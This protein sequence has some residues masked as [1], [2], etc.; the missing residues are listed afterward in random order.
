MNPI[1]NEVS[2]CPTCG[3]YDKAL[4]Y[5]KQYGGEDYPCPN[6]WHTTPSD[7][8]TPQPTT[9]PEA[10]TAGE[11]GK[12]VGELMC[13]MR[14]MGW[15]VAVHNDYRLG[16]KDHTFWLFTKGEQCVK[17]EGV[18]DYSALMWA[19][20]RAQALA[21]PIATEQAKQVPSVNQ[22][23]EI[24]RKAIEES[25]SRCLITDCSRGAIA[26][27]REACGRGYSSLV[28]DLR[29]KLAWAGVEGS[30]PPGR[31]GRIQ[32]LEQTVADLRKEAKKHDQLAS[33]LTS[34]LQDCQIKLDDAIKER[35][36]AKKAISQYASHAEEMK[37]ELAEFV[38]PSE[39]LILCISSGA[40][41]AAKAI[42]DL[43]RENAALAEQKANWVASYERLNND[44]T[45]ARET[46][47]QA[48]RYQQEL[49]EA[50]RKAEDEKE[51]LRH[52]A[53]LK[54]TNREDGDGMTANQIFGAIE[55][56]QKR[57]RDGQQSYD[58]LKARLLDLKQSG[59]WVPLT[60]R[61][62]TKEDSISIGSR[63][64]H[65]VMWWN[66]THLWIHPFDNPD[67]CDGKP[68]THWRVISLP[69]PSPSPEAPIITNY[70][71]PPIPIRDHDWSAYRDGYEG[72]DPIG[73]GVTKED[74]IAD[75]K[76][77]EEDAN[78]ATKAK[79]GKA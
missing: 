35:D 10:K 47:S 70:V 2:K 66:G 69:A 45:T 19:I 56:M 53:S 13:R 36:E 37:K 21:E 76:Q 63:S 24:F 12:G 59:G 46:I 62:P 40:R 18:D 72:G 65:S 15:S 33:V 52:H 17:G 27:V 22:C 75:L 7:V 25:G 64:P 60:E 74:A 3:S 58:D 9:Q 39:G 49:R 5:I 30:P 26:A 23:C 11:A 34:D 54:I 16:G 1:Q 73:W 50:L 68:P 55:V 31:M 61:N 79:G 78:D 32:E 48:E 38:T 44:L 20:G 41:N 42:A 71:H 51:Y 28:A 4:L 29:R 14:A 43:R 57:I 8:A 77:Q 6:A 67:T